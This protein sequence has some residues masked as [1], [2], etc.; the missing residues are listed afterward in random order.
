MRRTKR[1]KF[2]SSK[3]KTVRFDLRNGTMELLEWLTLER[4]FRG[5]VVVDVTT[6]YEVPVRRRRRR[7]Q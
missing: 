3:G 7:R 2:R 1:L 6:V 4:Y 5:I